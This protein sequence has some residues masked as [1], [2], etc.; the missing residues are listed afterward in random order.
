MKSKNVITGSANK[1]TQTSVVTKSSTTTR[2]TE[3]NDSDDKSELSTINFS[4]DFLINANSSS[5]NVDTTVSKL[6]D[7][8]D[9]E[10]FFN[11]NVNSDLSNFEN[12]Q[13][14][15][16]A[17]MTLRMVCTFIIIYF[18]ESVVLTSK[19]KITY[20]ASMLLTLFSQNRIFAYN[21]YDR[22]MS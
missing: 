10:D 11:L 9:A 20:A 5:L 4:R 3:N 1:D 19:S 13:S 17:G 21:L 22:S 2:P 7:T 16:F 8:N 15:N 12:L 18:T 14:H 6:D